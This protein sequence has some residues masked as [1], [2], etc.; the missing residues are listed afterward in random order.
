MIDDESMTDNNWIVAYNDDV[1]VGAR[2]W[3]GEYTDIPAM[4]YDGSTQTAGYMEVG[5]IPTFKLLNSEGSLVDLYVDGSIANWANNGVDVITLSS[6]PL[7]PVEIALNNSY[8]NPFNPSTTINFDV[9]K[10][11]QMNISIYNI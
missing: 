2:M 11:G 10:D 7:L 9:A 5:S 4:G 8:P 6:T 3:N 1:I